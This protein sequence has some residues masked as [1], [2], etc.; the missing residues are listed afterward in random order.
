MNSRVVPTGTVTGAYSLRGDKQRLS[1][2][3]HESYSQHG[4]ERD[5]SLFVAATHMPR[6]H[7]LI[8]RVS[9][10]SVPL[11]LVVLV[12][13]PCAA[14]RPIR[15]DVI[16]SAMV[17]SFTAAMAASVCDQQARNQ[18]SLPGF[19]STSFASQGNDSAVFIVEG[20]DRNLSF[21]SSLLV[22]LLTGS[23]TCESNFP[24]RLCA[25]F[26]RDAYAALLVADATM[27]SLSAQYPSTTLRVSNLVSYALL[28]AVNVASNSGV[29]GPTNADISQ[30]YSTPLTPA[31]Y[32]ILSR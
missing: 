7:G 12:D 17:A 23:T 29:L 20:G 14:H 8:E 21:S 4:H 27:S 26:C 25:L 22:L 16:T 3:A 2:L 1:S 11:P 9:A 15:H 31:G 5:S 18:L 13:A 32:V 30:R 6:T 24:W 10:L 28:I 19:A